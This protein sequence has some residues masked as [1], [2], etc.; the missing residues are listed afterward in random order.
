MYVVWCML[1]AICIICWPKC[2]VH[3]GNIYEIR[4]ANALFSYSLCKI[5]AMCV[6]FFDVCVTFTV[7]RN[8][9]I[10]PVYTR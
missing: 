1:C 3:I 9:L 7:S 6:V 8:T 4:V 10:Y 2:V 5:Y